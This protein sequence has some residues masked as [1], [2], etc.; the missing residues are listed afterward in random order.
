MI[1]SAHGPV[2]HHV[3]GLHMDVVPIDRRFRLGTDA[4]R[5]DSS[6]PEQTDD[7]RDDYSVPHNGLLVG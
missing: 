4:R 6:T 1:R 2:M 5:R 3:R 7:E